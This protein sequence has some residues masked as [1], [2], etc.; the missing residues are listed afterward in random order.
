MRAQCFVAANESLIIDAERPLFI[1]L[2][3]L[4]IDRD[5]GEGGGGNWARW[6][7]DRYSR[8]LNGIIRRQPIRTKHSRVDVL[9]PASPRLQQ[10]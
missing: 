8:A 3:S 9:T 10:V 7:A 4:L 5:C 6:H 2:M 1:I